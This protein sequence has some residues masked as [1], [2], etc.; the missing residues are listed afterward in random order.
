M[1]QGN[2]VPRVSGGVP[3]W[4][5]LIVVM[6]TGMFVLGVLV[7]QSSPDADEVW[8]AAAESARRLEIDPLR[9]NLE[10]YRDLGGDADRTDV[11]EGILA[12]ATNRSPRAISILE[13]Y[14]DHDD[15]ELRTLATR[16]A[17]VAHQRDGNLPRA[18][19]LY[20]AFRE[21][22]PD[23]PVSHLLLMRLYQAAGAVVAAAD[24]AEDV[25]RI[26]P[27]DQSAAQLIPQAY[28]HTGE[29]EKALDAYESILDS[30]AAIASA[31]PNTL[32]KY[33]KCLMSAGKVGAA[34]EFI[35]HNRAYI[36]NPAI[37]VS[38]FLKN[39]MI[40]EANQVLVEIEAQEEKGDDPRLRG[41]SIRASLEGIRVQAALL[42]KSGDFKQARAVLMETVTRYPRTKDVYEQLAN[43]AREVGDDELAEVCGQNIEMLLEIERQIPDAVRRIGSDLTMPDLRVEVAKL[44]RE[45]WND[46]EAELWANAA[47]YTAGNGRQELLRLLKSIDR[48]NSTLVPFKA[49]SSSAKSSESTDA[50]QP[51]STVKKDARDKQDDVAS[52]SPESAGIS[53]DE[54]TDASKDSEPSSA[55]E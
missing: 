39:G 46:D 18:E 17:A 31:D 32:Y 2:T 47:S 4:L 44:H 7:Q 40:D 50:S 41:R 21:L 49:E 27:M 35:K 1:G 30:D 36:N 23:N 16:Y 29:L 38:V 25:L 9:Q 24:I 20:L 28:Q 6:A 48:P 10:T 3:W 55:E 14:L 34:A 8:A 26:E 42:M 51:G 22:A 13:P 11:L 33:L 53:A 52:E 12:G 37:T 5:W 19:E 15:I 54:P 43:L 45:L